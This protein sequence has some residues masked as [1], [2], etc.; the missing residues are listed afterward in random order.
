MLQFLRIKD[1]FKSGTVMPTRFSKDN[2]YICIFTFMRNM[3]LSAVSQT[4]FFYCPGDILIKIR[5]M[6]S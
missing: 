4:G 6:L 1:I 2:S 5:R 3:I